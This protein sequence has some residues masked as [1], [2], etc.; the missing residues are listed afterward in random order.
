MLAKKTGP[1]GTVYASIAL[2]EHNTEVCNHAFVR[3]V[4]SKAIESDKIVFVDASAMQKSLAGAGASAPS[5][6]P[7]STK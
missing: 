7:R 5:R 3:V 6:S 1:S 2:A 4:E